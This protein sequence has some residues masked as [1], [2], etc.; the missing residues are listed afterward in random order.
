M[1]FMAAKNGAQLSLAPALEKRQSHRAI[2]VN[3]CARQQRAGI[4][5]FCGKT[6]VFFWGCLPS[7]RQKKHDRAKTRKRQARNRFS[8]YCGEP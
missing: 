1:F 4:G 2:W 7:D 5:F 8:D 6:P 3:N